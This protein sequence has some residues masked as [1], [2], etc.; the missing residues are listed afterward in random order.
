MLTPRTT[1]PPGA[2]RYR[3]KQ[4]RRAAIMVMPQNRGTRPV[5]APAPSEA[6]SDVSI[7]P[8][9]LI[10]IEPRTADVAM[11]FEEAVW[12]SLGVQTPE[13]K[14]TQVGETPGMAT[15][16]LFTEDVEVQA[17]P[18]KTVGQQTGLGEIQHD[19][20][21]FPNISFGPRYRV[22]FRGRKQFHVLNRLPLDEGDKLPMFAYEAKKPTLA[23]IIPRTGPCNRRALLAKFETDADLVYALKMEAAFQ[24][25]SVSL[26][27]Q[28]KQKAR[29]WLA[30]WDLS[31]YTS[32]EIYEMAMKAVGQA[33]LV[34]E[35]EERIRALLH[36]A[37]ERKFIR[38]AQNSFLVHGRTG[39]DDG[40]C[41]DR[42]RGKG[43][44]W[45]TACWRKWTRAT[46]F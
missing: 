28:L 6:G 42:Q 14:E 3:T 34:D 18:P 38:P 10:N 5:V 4:A 32:Q 45:W 12:K 17:Q 44:A 9:G 29:K 23:P 20:A 31:A 19:A 7:V 16:T 22:G 43:A 2:I 39:T 26:L 46:R 11:Q 8:E 27:L 40:S 13:H 25:R 35:W 1:L 21:P 41:L 24:Q 37:E 30:A 33:M 15:N 36:M